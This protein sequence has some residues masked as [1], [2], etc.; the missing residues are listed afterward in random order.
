MSKDETTFPGWPECM[1]HTSYS[2]WISGVRKVP[3]GTGLFY[4]DIAPILDSMPHP[5]FVKQWRQTR[6]ATVRET[7]I[8]FGLSDVQVLQSTGNTSK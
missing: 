4:S 1:Q 6:K 2:E 5:E 7:A 8:H 3:M